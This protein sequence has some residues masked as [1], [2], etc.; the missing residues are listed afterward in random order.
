[1][2]GSSSLLLTE[3]GSMAPASVMLW[4]PIWFPPTSQ[5]VTSVARLCLSPAQ[6]WISLTWMWHLPAVAPEP[7]VVVYGGVVAAGVGVLVLVPCDTEASVVP[8]A[9]QELGSTMIGSAGSFIILA[10]SSI[11]AWIM[12][13]ATIALPNFV[14]WKTRPILEVMLAWT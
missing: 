14:K 4:Y 6:F 3:S 11:M 13:L 1:M 7:P 12:L 10:C 2:S 8:V 9:G 5:M